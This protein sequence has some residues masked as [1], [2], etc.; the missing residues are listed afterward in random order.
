MAGRTKHMERSHYSY[1][2][3]Y[4][5]F[6]RFAIKADHNKYSKAAKASL[7]EKA[8]TGIKKMFRRQA[9]GDK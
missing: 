1:G 4:S 5:E 8:I 6:R 9:K 3:N 7:A 2:K